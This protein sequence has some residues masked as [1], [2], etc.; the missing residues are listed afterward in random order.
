MHFKELTH[1]APPIICNRR[2]FQIL[3]LFQ[4]KQIRDD[5]SRE[6]SA[7]RRF[8]RNITPY[9]CRILGKMLHSLSCAAVVIG[10]LKG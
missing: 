4:K 7:G 3:L 2:Q 1:K 5:I 9:F 10:T 8:S 6:S